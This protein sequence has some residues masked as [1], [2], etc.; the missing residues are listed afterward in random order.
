V[1][2]RS[3]SLLA[4]S[5][6]AALA[7]L[8]TGCGGEGGARAPQP[9]VPPTWSA[10]RDEA[11]AGT[12]MLDVVAGAPCR[13][14]VRIEGLPEGAVAETA[15]TMAA[16]ESAR[17][18]V[19]FL[20]ASDRARVDADVTAADREAGR[21]D[22]WILT[23]AY[24]WEDALGGRRRQVVG[25][26]H[27]RGRLLGPWFA[28]PSRTPTPLAFDAD[29]DLAA[30]AIVDGAETVTLDARETGS[31]LRGALEV[32]AGDRATLLRVVLRAERLEP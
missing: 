9:T 29:L 25:T 13:I 12:L 28:I 2:R 30:A 8:P 14:R 7:L 15:R 16:G 3:A 22:G 11:E 26:R 1:P 4:A 23:P 10:A 6:A 27:D 31:R 20:E 17:L 5:L 19:R 32:G 24:Q 21:T 18:S